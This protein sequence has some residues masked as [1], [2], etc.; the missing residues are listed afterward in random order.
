MCIDE[1]A[2]ST[3]QS[4]GDFLGTCNRNCTGREEDNI[5]AS[6]D[7]SLFL[8]PN[9]SNGK[10]IIDLML[11]NNSNDVADVQ[12]LNVFGQV[13]FANQVALTEGELKQEINP[14]QKIP[15]GNYFVRVILD[16]KIFTGQIVVQE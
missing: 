16:D 3:H 11:A 12:V 2:W 15:A 14:D 13:I 1:S 9:P 10:F 6:T 4:H 5:V 8:Y 7:G